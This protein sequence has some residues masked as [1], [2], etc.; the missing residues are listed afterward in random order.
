MSDTERVAVLESEMDRAE[1]DIR[2]HG[3]HIGELLEFMN[4]TRI[5]LEGIQGSVNSG[6]KLSWAIIAILLG[7]LLKVFWP[8]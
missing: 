1:E 7:M 6:N 2:R 4:E 3:G 8:Q 5:K